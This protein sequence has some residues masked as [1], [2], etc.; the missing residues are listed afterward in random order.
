MRAEPINEHPVVFVVATTGSGR[1]PRA[2]TPLWQMLLRADLPEDLLEEL[3]FAFFGLGDTAYE[4]F[5]WPAKLLSRRLQALGALEL[6][7]RG[8]GDEQHHLG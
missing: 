5:C 2:R 4:K 7:A 1:E 6:C 8:E 3:H